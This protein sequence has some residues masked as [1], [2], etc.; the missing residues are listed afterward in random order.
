MELSR[1]SLVPRASV[2]YFVGMSE[3]L[4]ECACGQTLQGTRIA[5]HQVLPCPGCQ[6]P[7]FIFPLSPWAALVKKQ[8]AGPPKTTRFRP[9]DLVVPIGAG[10]ATLLGLLLLYLFVIHPRFVRPVDPNK[11]KAAEASPEALR[12]RLDQARQ[13]LKVGKFRQAQQSLQFAKLEALTPEERRGWRQLDSEAGILADLLAEPLEDLLKH[14]AGSP[15]EEWP[16]E[17][18][19]RYLGKSLIVDAEFRWFPGRGWQANYHL[20][21]P[22]DMARIAWDDV[23]VFHKIPTAEKRR[24]ILG[25]RL[26]GLELTPPGPT[27]VVRLQPEKGILLTEVDALSLCC[28]GLAE[29]ENRQVLEEQRRFLEN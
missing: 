14:A 5:R 25:V 8:Q 2:N 3:Y 27:W 9:R 15:P 11:V 12:Q 29:P 1:Y 23:Q 17:F 13:M 24:F 19:E 10:V 18:R 7:L 22:Q 21:M 6:A 20:G 4:V 16:A 26:A 28:P